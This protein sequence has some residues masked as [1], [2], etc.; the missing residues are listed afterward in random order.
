MSQPPRE[1]PSVRPVSQGRP[2]ERPSGRPAGANAPVGPGGPQRPRTTRSAAPPPP[3]QRQ[4]PF[5]YI[6]GG[7]IGALVVGLVL[8]IFLLLN[9]NNQ[10]PSSTTTANNNN[11]GTSPNNLPTTDPASLNPEP[12]VEPAPRMA[13]AEF[14]ALYDDPDRRPLIVDVRA[15]E[16]FQ[17]GHIEGAVNIPE[18]EVPARVAEFPKDKLIVAYC[19]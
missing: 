14:K 9:N 17:Q 1:R 15:A 8:V 10:N 18:A 7:I 16:A 4:D 19:Q 11:P 3:P 6:M 12:T 13:L 5:P 2:P